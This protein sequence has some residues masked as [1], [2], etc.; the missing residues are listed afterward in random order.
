MSLNNE[1]KLEEDT[2]KSTTPSSYSSYEQEIK[3]QAQ[4]EQI[5]NEIKS[6][7]PLTSNLKPLSTLLQIYKPKPKP[8]EEEEKEKGH[9]RCNN[10]N[11]CFQLGC[12]YLI[13]KYKSWRMI[14]GD[15]NCYYRA[16]L[17]ALCETLLQR[18][19]KFIHN[20]SDVSDVSDV[21]N[22][23]NLDKNMDPELQRVK[24]YGTSYT[25]TYYVNSGVFMNTTMNCFFLYIIHYL[26]L[27]LI[28]L[29]ILLFF[30]SNLI[31]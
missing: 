3:T 4:I 17:Y 20:V 22:V 18:Q 11:H 30:S 29:Y 28:I 5:Q 26:I 2:T 13:K 31:L 14:R 16:F 8:N 19:L 6:N 24:Q 21:S 9:E 15:G 23:S 12:E 10:D 7:Q 1:S 27:I 25:S